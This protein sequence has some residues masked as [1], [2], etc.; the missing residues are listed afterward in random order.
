MRYTLYR[1]DSVTVQIAGGEPQ[2]QTVGHTAF[3]TIDFRAIAGETQIEI[4]IDS[5]RLDPDVAFPQI[6]VDSAVGTRWTGGFS[7]EGRLEHLVAGKSS[8]VGDQMRTQ[9][10]TLFP[11]LPAAGVRVG[12]EWT[13]SSSNPFKT[14]TFDATEQGTTTYHATAQE[15]RDGAAAIRIEGVRSAT[16]TGTSN[17]FGQDLAL[18]GAASTTVVYYVGFAGRLLS[19]EGAE[20]TDLS[21]TV[22]SVGQT[23]PAKLEASFMFSEVP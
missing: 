19:A 11:V 22:Q 8:L 3:L 18:S 6:M 7:P 1:R 2:V 17:Q 14:S 12:A 20:S 10:N 4:T 15:S 16:L 23:V 13:D 5:I 9:L 21:I